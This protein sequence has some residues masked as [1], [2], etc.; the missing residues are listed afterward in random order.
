MALTVPY[1]VAVFTFSVWVR[2]CACVCVTHVVSC[3]LVLGGGLDGVG[4]ETKDGAGP[5][6]DGE[7]TE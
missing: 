5:Q 7:A 4:Q 3:R 2:G 1:S 6:Q